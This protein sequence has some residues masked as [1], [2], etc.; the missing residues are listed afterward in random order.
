MLYIKPEPNYNLFKL[1]KMQKSLSTDLRSCKFNFKTATG[2]NK[3]I[4]CFF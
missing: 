1:V 3:Q 2:A 4:H